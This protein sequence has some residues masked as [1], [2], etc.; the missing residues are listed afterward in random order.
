MIGSSC[1]V[2]PPNLYLE[3]RKEVH[4]ELDKLEEIRRAANDLWVNVTM[5]LDTLQGNTTVVGYSAAC[6]KQS[7]DKLGQ[8]L[9][10]V[11]TIP[12]I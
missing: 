10:V 11:P 9:G 4:K 5:H 12:C 7:A 2:V 6:L 1:N 8:L 3:A